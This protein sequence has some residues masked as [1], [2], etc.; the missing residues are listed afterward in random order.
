[1]KNLLWLTLVMVLVLAKSCETPQAKDPWEETALSWRQTAL[2]AKESAK[3]WEA[4][5]HQ[6]E[7]NSNR[8]EAAA[9]ESQRIARQCIDRRRREN[10]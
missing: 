6:W 10:K 4:V 3:K 1:M 9:I 5:A 7:A 2:M 8:F